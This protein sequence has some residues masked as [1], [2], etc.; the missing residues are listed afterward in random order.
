[1][2]VQPVQLDSANAD[3]AQPF[4]ALGDIELHTVTVIE[5]LE[6][7]TG[8]LSV[9]HKDILAVFTGNESKSFG[10]VEPLYCSLFHGTVPFMLYKSA[11]GGYGDVHP[12]RYL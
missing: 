4:R 9:M 1:M 7:V 2:C 8:D 10:S 6:P 5:V 12:G 3:R 11:A